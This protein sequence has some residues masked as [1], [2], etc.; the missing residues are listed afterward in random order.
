[1][2]YRTKKWLDSGG[3]VPNDTELI[4]ELSAH[5]VYLDERGKIKRVKK[6]KIKEVLRR[7]PDKADSLFLAHA[8]DV[9]PL[10][11]HPFT[12]ISS[13]DNVMG[14]SQLIGVSQNNVTD[15]DPYDIPE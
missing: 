14:Y 10:A 7:S 15:Y 13:S 1:M 6:D 8:F 4:E 3:K 11:V 2:M 9:L 12:N 5:R